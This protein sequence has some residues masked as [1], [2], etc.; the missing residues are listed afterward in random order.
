MIE[1]EIHAVDKDAV[2][3]RVA[4]MEDLL[5][6]SVTEP[7]FRALLVA[8]FGALALVLAAVG[9]YGVIAYSVTQRTQEIGIRMALGAQ[10]GRCLEKSFWPEARCSH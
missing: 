4:T 1:R 8:G 7:R 10:R 9:I 3:R 2:V 5:S 6:E